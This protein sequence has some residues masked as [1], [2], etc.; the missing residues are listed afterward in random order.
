MQ[1]SEKDKDEMSR[2]YFFIFIADVT[3]ATKE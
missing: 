3:S 1:K 2:N